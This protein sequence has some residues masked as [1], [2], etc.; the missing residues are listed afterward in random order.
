[1]KQQKKILGKLDTPWY[2]MGY[3]P[4]IQQ[5]Q[6]LCINMMMILQQTPSSDTPTSGTHTP[7]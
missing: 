4:L 6:K 2:S 1:M 3:C 5:E 7:H